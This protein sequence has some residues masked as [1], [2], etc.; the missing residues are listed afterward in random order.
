MAQKHIRPQHRHKKHFIMGDNWVNCVWYSVSYVINGQLSSV[1]VSELQLHTVRLKDT[2]QSVS[3]LRALLVSY[4]SNVEILKWTRPEVWCA[5][6][7]WKNNICHGQ[8]KITTNSIKLFF[9]TLSIISI[10]KL[11]FRSWIL[12]PSSRKKE[13]GERPGQ[14]WG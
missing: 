12:L 1:T 11:R 6:C 9:R 13:G 7:L 14:V 10:I 5:G 3:K 4:S 2:L 8:K